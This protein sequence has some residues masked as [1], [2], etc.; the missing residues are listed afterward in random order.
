L[1]AALAAGGGLAAPTAAQDIIADLIDKLTGDGQKDV[2]AYK[3]ARARFEAELVAYWDAVGA[4]RTE[5]RKK[6]RA[7][8]T[9]SADDYVLVFPPEYRGPKLTPEISAALAQEEEGKPK[10]PPPDPLP[11][12]ADFL[13]QAQAVY[14]FE[15]ERVPEFEF[16]RRYAREALSLR[17]TKE[18]VVR[19][20]AF[21]TGGNG[22]ADMQSGINPITKQGKA[23]STA[24]GYAQLLAGNSI[25]EVVKHGEE[26]IQRLGRMAGVP[27]TPQ[28]RVA[29]LRKKQVA[30]RK[31]LAKAR[32]VPAEWAAHVRLGNTPEGMGIHALNLDGDIGPWLQ[33]IKLANIVKF[34]TGEGRPV[35]TPAELEIMNL[36]GPATG[37]EMMTVT[38]GSMPTPN[39][40]TRGAYERNS[41]VRGR[42]GAE[43]LLEIDRRMDSGMR[44]PGSIEFARAFDEV[45]RE[46]R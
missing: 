11:V 26:F 8:G 5:R 43:L 22:T 15:P 28:P 36:A 31:M 23:I 32:T 46:G 12:V 9:A 2:Q 40:F 44:Q 18:Q 3:E 6:F 14:D 1:A 19:V 17:L 33:A 38:G 45:M 13:A 25:D 39:F 21:E 30:L 41:V 42:T 35:L 27:G 10:P 20:Y 7:G 37:L 16:K 24:L 4:K 34:A 29:A